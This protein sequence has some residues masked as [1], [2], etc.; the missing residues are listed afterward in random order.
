MLSFAVNCF[1][2]VLWLYCLWYRLLGFPTY[3]HENIHGYK[4]LPNNYVH[5]GPWRLWYPPPCLH[6]WYLC[7]C[8]LHWE[9]PSQPAI[10]PTSAYPCVIQSPHNRSIYVVLES[11]VLV[12]TLRPR[13]MAAIFQTTSWNAFSWMRMFDSRLRFDGTLFHRVQSTIFQH[14]F[15]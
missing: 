15:R 2:V 8:P 9:I 5:H 11:V 12:N 3:C 10:S 4:I 14:W 6:Y 7:A 13:Q 1:V